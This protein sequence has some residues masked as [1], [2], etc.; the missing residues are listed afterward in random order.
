M[1]EGEAGLDSG[2]R[3][4]VGRDNGR[5]SSGG[6]SSRT[7]LE[8]HLR[9]NRLRVN[10]P[11]LGQRVCENWGT[12][13]E[14]LRSGNRRLVIS[15]AGEEFEQVSVKEIDFSRAEVVR[16]IGVT[17]S[18]V[19]RI[20]ASRELP[21]EVRLKYQIPQSRSARTSLF[22]PTSSAPLRRGQTGF[23]GNPI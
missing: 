5:D 11:L 16:F 10:L 20:A 13:I 18:C 4:G 7:C 22:F 6:R 15:K 17:A 19:T 3:K 23:R 12:T 2:Y 21:E 1:A 8:P 9:S 14:E